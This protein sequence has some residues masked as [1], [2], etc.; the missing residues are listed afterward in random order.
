M[1]RYS[2]KTGSLFQ[3]SKAEAGWTW[4][5]LGKGYSGRG[6]GLNN[7]EKE[8]VADIGPCPVGI[9]AISFPFTDT[10]RGPLCFRLTPLTYKGARRGFLIH[11]DNTSANHTASE[12]CIILGHELRQKL[13][14][15]KADYLLVE[16]ED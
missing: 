2:Q 16:A 6:E 15:M 4:E 7:P 3:Y 9:W 13:A 11:G 12:G 8:D 14:D 10:K 1:L 5:T